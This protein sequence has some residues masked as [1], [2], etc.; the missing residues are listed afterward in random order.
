M[1][2]DTICN[3]T[4]PLQQIEPHTTA[5]YALLK[6]SLPTGITNDFMV[7]SARHPAF[8][9]AI[10]RLPS[11]HE[12]TRFWA[13][14]QPY[15]AIML[16]SGPLFLTLA[17]KDYLLGRPFLPSPT[18][19]TINSSELAPYITD[20]ETASWHHRD[21]QILM[22]L[23]DKPWAWFVLGMLG[24]GAGM[25]TFN[26]MMARVLKALYS[27]SCLVWFVVHLPDMLQSKRSC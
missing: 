7:S 1:D 14:L 25:Y 18:V 8:A 27:K 6:T 26:Y 9:A 20:L 10:T 22:W 3:K 24:L 12:K 23:G 13:R 21:A 19:E 5:T 11:F 16:S 2:M 4:L 15:T 17:V